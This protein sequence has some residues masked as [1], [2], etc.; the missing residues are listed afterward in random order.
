MALALANNEGTLPLEKKIK[1]F[2][3]EAKGLVFKMAHH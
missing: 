3:F 2:T 1:N